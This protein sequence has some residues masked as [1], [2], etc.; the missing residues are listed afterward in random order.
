MKNKKAILFVVIVFGIFIFF[1]AAEA[2][3]GP[4]VVNVSSDGETYNLDSDDP[5]VRVDFDEDIINKPRISV[6]S[7]PSLFLPISPIPSPAYIYSPI[8][9]QNVND[10]DDGDSK[11]FC[12]KYNV[13][14]STQEKKVIYISE[15]Q[16]DIENKMAEDNTHT[17]NVDTVRPSIKNISSDGKTYDQFSYLGSTI[18]T[19]KITFNEGIDN[20]PEVSVRSSVFLL[21]HTQDVD[22]CGDSDART[23]CFDCPYDNLKNGINSI[24]VSKAK[25][26]AGNTML[27]DHSHTFKMSLGLIGN[28]ITTFNLGDKG[29][30]ATNVWDGSISGIAIEKA[31]GVKYIE[32]KISHKSFGS[33]EINYWNGTNWQEGETAVHANGK[34]A[35]NYKIPVTI[36]EGIY[37]VYSKAVY[38]DYSTSNSYSINIVYDMTKPEVFASIYPAENDGN[39]GWYKSKPKITLT[40]SDN[41]DVEGIEYQ[42]NSNSGTWL[43]YTDPITIDNGTWK[44]YYRSIDKASNY[45]FIGEKEIKVDAEDPNEISDL[46]AKYDSEN[47]F[48]NLSWNA[49]DS[50]IDMVYIY[51]GKSKDFKIDNNSRIAKNEKNDENYTD[52]NVKRGEKYYYKFVSLD[53]VGNNSDAKV[54]SIEI[55]TETGSDIII[56]DEGTEILSEDIVIGENANSLNSNTKQVLAA[57]INNKNED[58]GEVLGTESKNTVSSETEEKPKSSGQFWWYAFLGVVIF[59]LIVNWLRMRRKRA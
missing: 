42:L 7:S 12:F 13:P 18:P 55:P 1:K 53:E 49:D 9:A 45:S 15:A 47:V 24:Y 50:D 44:L 52:Q 28:Y 36:P 27:E 21:S 19:I 26:N 39:N 23:F 8:F 29:L 40:A 48:V 33:E 57:E 4:S 6:I 54:I 38:N 34:G 20:I 30:I 25:D 37:G 10:C 16:D 2:V 59:I 31:S 5:V 17:F 35:W 46:D 41:Y 43:N 58:V 22:N 3:S 51:K 56:N 11:T 32:L 14:S